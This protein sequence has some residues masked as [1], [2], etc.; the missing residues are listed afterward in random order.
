ML[1]VLI[2]GGGYGSVSTCKAHWTAHL[3]FGRFILSYISVFL[4]YLIKK[5]MAQVTGPEFKSWLSGLPESPC[6]A[7]PLSPSLDTGPDGFKD[8]SWHGQSWDSVNS[9][10]YLS[11]SLLGN[12]A[13]TCHQCGAKK[14]RLAVCCGLCLVSKEGKVFGN[15][16]GTRHSQEAM[17]VSIWIILCIASNFLWE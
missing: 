6:P 1:S 13:S 17:S 15:W 11:L 14:R 10:T 3:R 5:M 12:L 4:K 16:A 2:C 7:V 8:S 9:H